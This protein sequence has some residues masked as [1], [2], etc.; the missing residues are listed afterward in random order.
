MAGGGALTQLSAFGQIDELL[1][2][3]LVNAPDVVTFFKHIHRKHTSFALEWV[4]YPLSQFQLGQ[5]CEYTFPKL[6]DLIGQIL[7]K[8]NLPGLTPGAGDSYVYWVND[9]VYAAIDTARILFGNQCAD[10]QTGEWMHIWRKLPGKLS[11][12]SGSPCSQVTTC[13]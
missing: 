2:S 6:A 8:F 9:F 1:K 7:I 13:P 11:C 4:E 12:R 5:R 10:E 3:K